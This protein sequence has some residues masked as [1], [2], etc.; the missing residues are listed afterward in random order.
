M[1]KSLLMKGRFFT[2]ASVAQWQ[3]KMKYH[4][5]LMDL[6]RAVCSNNCNFPKWRLS[7]ESGDLINLGET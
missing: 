2:Y 7:R 3:Q 1:M 4:F 6:R 5:V